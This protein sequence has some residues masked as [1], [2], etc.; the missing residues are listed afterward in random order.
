MKKIF[1]TG[2]SGFIGSNLVKYLLK[3]NYFVINIDKLSYSANSYNLKEA[4]KKNYLFFKLDINN[5]KKLSLLIKKYKPSA[6]FNLAAE[7]HVDRS[8]DSP[9]SFISSN[10]NGVFNLLEC[11][12]QYNKKNKKKIK[13]IH[14]STDEVFGDI[15]NTNQRSDEK[16]P[17]KPSSPYSASKASADHLVNAYVRTYKIPAMISNCSNNYGPG[18]FPEKLIPKI[19]YNITNNKK[20][21]VYGKGKNSREWIYVDD[22]CKAL[23]MLYLKGRSGE[24]YNVGSG[25]N[26]TN[27][28]LIKKILKIFKK[29]G[30]KMGSNVKINYVKDRPGHDLRYALNSKKIFKK[31]KWQAN[32][33]LEK[34]LS[35][36]IDWYLQ[37]KDFFKNSKKKYFT[38]RLGLKI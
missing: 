10:I 24:S 33:P 34:G 15:I 13:L 6:I 11:I 30:F 25:K 3:K 5:K 21:P 12:R 4:N 37:N 27:I 28:N 17:Y 8:I 14:I 2:G 1:I 7:T 22:H 19:I 26:L 16:F 29:K 38:K 23:F 18:Q 31:I 32:T 36:T 9:E 35:K 20:L